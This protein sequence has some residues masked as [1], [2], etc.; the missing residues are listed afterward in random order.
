MKTVK[1]TILKDLESVENLVKNSVSFT[2]NV[3]SIDEYSS[4][5]R[6]VDG[7]EIWTDALNA[8]L[9]KH[10]TVVIPERSIPYYID[11]TVLIPSN[12]SIKAD[13]TARIC[14]TPDCDVLMLRN[15]ETKDGTH[16]P[17]PKSAPKNINI[18]ISGGI[19]EE[20]RDCRMGYGKSGMYDKERSFFGVSTCMLF[21]NI[22]NLL[23]SDMTFVHT[24]GFSVQIGDIK[25][26]VFEN[27]KFVECF[28]DGLHIN[29]NSENLIIRNISGDVGDD[30]VA[31]NLYDWQNS[32]VNFGPA[33]NILCENLQLLGKCNYPAMRI[34]PGTY[35]YDD[36]SAIDCSLERAIIRN[37]A[38]I[39]TFK[40]YYQTPPY[41][42][43]K[44]PEKGAV[45][46]CDYLF[47]ENICIDLT[48]PIDLLEPYT[49]SDP[50]RGTI[51]AFEL[52]ANIG[53]LS[54]EDIELT[55]HR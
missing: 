24:A 28:A 20:S 10:Q 35:Y 51:A 40:L 47:F 25:N 42:L 27:I 32:S 49:A 39:R 37:V 15:T 23:L 14:L 50:I 6:T 55:L 13:G 5:K 30:L 43:N 53:H 19:W 33:K 12:R 9:E 8:A 18:S 22:E 46:S 1:A 11:G 31:L 34:E 21:N 2:D 38:G 4:L 17:I 29:G 41:A 44:A 7:K 3:V 52:G 26:A 45:G 54:F 48:Q 36:G 16:T